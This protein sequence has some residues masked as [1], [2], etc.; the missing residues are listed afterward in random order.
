MIFPKGGKQKRMLV[1]LFLKSHSWI[2]AK[3]RCTGNRIPHSLTICH[4]FP[5]NHGSV[6]NCQ[7]LGRETIVL[8]EPPQNCPPS[9]MRRAIQPQTK[10]D[11][12]RSEGGCILKFVFHQN[13]QISTVC[14]LMLVRPFLETYSRILTFEHEG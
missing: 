5:N 1:E 2:D 13:L 7:I 4:S 8:H 6:E 3:G 11:E 14:F 10:C 12:E 9:A